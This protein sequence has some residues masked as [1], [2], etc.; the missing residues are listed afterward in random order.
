MLSSERQVNL[1]GAY[2]LVDVDLRCVDCRVGGCV[3]LYRRV[4]SNGGGGFS[5]VK[6]SSSAHQSRWSGTFEN[7]D[8]DLRGGDSRVGGG[9]DVHLYRR[10]NA[11]G[12]GGFSSMKSSSSDGDWTLFILRATIDKVTCR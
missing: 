6:D 9:G 7:V 4:N 3:H 11:N 2:S 8:L 5:I 1:S 10:V 12:G